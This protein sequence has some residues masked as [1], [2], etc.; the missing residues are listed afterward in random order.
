MNL[1]IKLVTTPSILLQCSFLFDFQLRV[2]M[3]YICQYNSTEAESEK[4]QQTVTWVI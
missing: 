4:Q 3:T 1:S 2:S